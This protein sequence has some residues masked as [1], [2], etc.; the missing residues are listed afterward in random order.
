MNCGT[1]QNYSCYILMPMFLLSDTFGGWYGNWCFRACS[2]LQYPVG[3]RVDSSSDQILPQ[4]RLRKWAVGIATALETQIIHLGVLGVCDKRLMGVGTRKRVCWKGGSKQAN[5]LRT[6][7]IRFRIY[8]RYGWEPRRHTRSHEQTYGGRRGHFGF[9][10]PVI[11]SCSVTWPKASGSKGAVSTSRLERDARKKAHP[12]L[13][14]VFFHTHRLPTLCKHVTL[15]QTCSPQTM[16]WCI[17][18]SLL[19]FISTH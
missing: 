19:N 3:G 5:T 11:L 1:W 12:S 8:D 9:H 4:Q 16:K 14:P 2:C 10:R 7:K 17:S 18:M 13:P 15:K 6:K